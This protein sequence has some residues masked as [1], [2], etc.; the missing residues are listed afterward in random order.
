MVVKGQVLERGEATRARLLDAAR[1]LFGV[2]GF[3]ATSLDE[4]VASA[5]VTK[6]ALYHH[7]ASKDALFKAVAEAVK[8][9]TAMVLSD[10]FLTTDPFEAL[11]AGCSAMLDAYLD[12]ST[13]QIVWIDAPAVFSADEYRNLQ[14]RFEPVFLRAVLRRA[15]RLGAIEVQPLRPLVAL[16]TGA[17]GEACS[18]IAS[19]S[20]REA[21]RQEVLQAIRRLLVGLRATPPT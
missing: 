11:V 3:A 7:F 18:L 8:Q 6:G 15:M 20:D 5:G 4:V 14:T 13:H 16:L 17:I 1:E 21:V 9:D 12:P 2:H 10:L 19:S